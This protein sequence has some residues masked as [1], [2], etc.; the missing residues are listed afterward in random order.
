M[1]RLLR[2]LIC[3]FL[4]G[5]LAAAQTAT[6]TRKVNLRS[7]PSTDYDPITKL[8]PPAQPANWTT[9]NLDL[10]TR[11]GESTYQWLANA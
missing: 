10:F 4:G 9:S 1:N 11:T 7:D 2:L 8:T 3:V 5:G 6:V